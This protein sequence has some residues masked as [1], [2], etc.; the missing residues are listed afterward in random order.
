VVEGKLKGVDLLD[1]NKHNAF[2][3]C[4]RFFKLWLGRISNMWMSWLDLLRFP[5]KH[6]DGD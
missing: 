6:E 2:P 3:I 4:K 5:K 1:I